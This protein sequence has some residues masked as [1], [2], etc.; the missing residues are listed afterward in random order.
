MESL[1]NNQLMRLLK[2]LTSAHPETVRKSSDELA[3]EFNDSASTLQLCAVLG[4]AEKQSELR[5]CAGNL[6]KT[7]LA[8]SE[9]WPKDIQR[10][11]QTE[12]LGALKSL[13]LDDD[14]TLQT[15]ILR[16]LSVMMQHEE[17]SEWN[18][19]VLNHVETLSKSQDNQQQTLSAIIFRLLAKMAPKMLQNYLQR[20]QR[21]F[22]HIVQQAE[23][24]G[25]LFSTATEQ[26]L[27]GWTLIVPLY[28]KR[29]TGKQQTE[30]A[31]TLPHIMKLTHAAAYHKSEVGLAT[32]PASRRGIAVL[33]KLNQQMPEMVT[34]HLQLVLDELCT[35]A[36]DI[37]L[38]DTLR[39]KAIVGIK[40]CV[41]S[42]R[43]HII[44]LKLMDKLLM[45]LCGLLALQPPK[46]D[47]HGEELFLGASSEEEESEAATPLS[48]AA[49]TINYVAAHSDTNRVADRALRLM[50][51]QLEQTES[52]L[53]RLG[54]LLFLSLMAKGFCDLL[55]DTHLD[56][57][58][59]AVERGFQDSDDLVRRG[60]HFALSVM[61]EN[62]QPEITRLAD[63]VLPLFYNF[64]DGLSAEQRLVAGDT[65]VYTRMFCTLEIYCE[66]LKPEMMQPH[67]AELMKRLMLLLQPN[68]NSPALRQMCLTTIASLAKL[69]KQLFAP[70]FDEVMCATMPLVKHAPDENQLLLR[71]HAIQVIN[72]LGQVNPEKFEKE[73]SNLFASC[74]DT[75]KHVAGAQMFT[76][77]LLGVL[78]GYIPKEINAHFSLIMNGILTSIKEAANVEKASES[79]KDD[80]EDDDD[81]SDAASTDEDNDEDDDDAENENDD[82]DDESED[83]DDESSTEEESGSVRD[84]HGDQTEASTR[85]T[86]SAAN[87][88]NGHDEAVMCLKA[89]AINMPNTLLPY[90]SESTQRVFTSTDHMEEL[91]KW[92]A[93]ETLTQFILLYS[94]QG[95]VSEAKKHCIQLLPAMVYF[96]QTAKETVNVVS[97]MKSIE[98]LLSVLK[99][100]ALAAEGY[101]EMV[102]EMLRRTLRRKLNCQFNIGIDQEME[103]LQQWSQAMYAEQQVMEAAGDLI[104]VFGHSLTKRQFASY[105]QTLSKSFV[106]NLRQSSPSGQVTRSNFFMYTLMGRS[107]EALGVMAEQY[108]EVLCYGILDCMQDQRRRIRDFARQQ[109]DWLLTHSTEHNNAETI[110]AATS[111]VFGDAL[112]AGSPTP[113]ALEKDERD[114]LIAILA[115]M[116]RIDNKCVAMNTLIPLFLGSLPLQQRFECYIDVMPALHVIFKARMDL[117]RPHLAEMLEVLLAALQAQHLP[118]AALRQMTIELVKCIK[119]DDEALYQQVSEKF[120]EVRAIIV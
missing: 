42:M 28:L 3:K 21:I 52:P 70:H 80:D 37:K 84:G 49:N 7:R 66:S 10:Q 116:I 79:S 19:S 43:R 38:S 12:L 111:C 113:T 35:L 106:K 9:S 44:R 16:N 32:S 85:S 33:C 5:K 90:L 97:V 94:K 115:R 61:A 45:T 55:A 53:K 57:F 89:F 2:D 81:D 48:E 26:L 15:L 25:Q 117:L 17:V 59:A 30:L 69:S 110:I 60:A 87:Y 83:E 98:Q 119:L 76:Y 27:H 54:A 18:E 20:A 109:I 24:Q 112:A 96:V 67:L 77:E 86:E 40:S 95:N 104:P 75:I 78:S 8:D 88:V 4:N 73:A 105:L 107:M 92:S 114:L 93:Y 64:F 50:Q 82:D 101:A 11:T 62:L 103:T 31:A 65:E 68:T 56:R 108:Y 6:L 99:S 72:A 120:M 14:E 100:D 23:A 29:A 36:S 58:V 41:R 63:R 91:D 13:R 39:V 71:T 22:M 74:L 47:E 102:F 46:L 118:N 34:P 1:V 51:P